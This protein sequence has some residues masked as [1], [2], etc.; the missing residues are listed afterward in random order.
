MVGVQAVEKGKSEVQ[1]ARRALLS[2]IDK[3]ENDV[4]RLAVAKVQFERAAEA[5]YEEWARA[6]DRAKATGDDLKASI[7]KLSTMRAEESGRSA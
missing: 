6:N 1:A 4:V 7:L 2:A 5:A 3:L